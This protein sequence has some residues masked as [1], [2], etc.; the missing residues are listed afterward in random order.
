M[1]LTEK[2][3]ELLTKENLHKKNQKQLFI[4]E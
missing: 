2:N 4:L 3:I 1:N